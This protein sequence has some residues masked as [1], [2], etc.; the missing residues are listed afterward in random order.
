MAIR[1]MKAR[2]V[3]R[4]M[5]RGGYHSS[6]VITRVDGRRIGNAERRPDKNGGRDDRPAGRSRLAPGR[7]NIRIAIVVHAMPAGSL[8]AEK[9][10]L[11]AGEG[12]KRHLDARDQFVSDRL[13]SL[14]VVSHTSSACSMR[15]GI[16]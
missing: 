4:D 7:V 10:G 12:V 1:A 13:R 15:S 3:A 8:R 2:A 6:I 9:P 16:V 5:A 11:L 14:P